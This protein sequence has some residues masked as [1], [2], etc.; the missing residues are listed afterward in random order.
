M[1]DEPLDLDLLAARDPLSMTAEDIDNIIAWHRKAQSDKAAGIKPPKPKA[2]DISLVVKSL[3]A[4][5]KPA[6]VLTRR[7]L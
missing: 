5:A 3:L 7:K 6:Q 4:N 1:S 2:A